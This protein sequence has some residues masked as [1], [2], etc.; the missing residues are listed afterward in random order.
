MPQVRSYNSHAAIAECPDDDDERYQCCCGIFHIV[1]GAKIVSVLLVVMAIAVVCFNHIIY[2]ESSSQ[3]NFSV[4]LYI[5]DVVILGYVGILSFGVFSRRRSLLLPFIVCQTITTA[6]FSLVLVSYAV[7]GSVTD[8]IRQQHN[9]ERLRAFYETQGWNP[10]DE[11]IQTIISCSILFVLLVICVCLVYTWTVF[12]FTYSYLKAREPCHHTCAIWAFCRKYT[13]WFPRLKSYLTLR[14]VAMLIIGR[15]LAGLI[16][17]VM[18]LAL[19]VMQLAL[20][21]TK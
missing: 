17:C 8:F 7:L 5:I 2:A 4:V 12:Y 21:A 9:N 3:T 1:T 13:S 19:E 11:K 6:I 15:L 14:D 10:N 18:Q 20:E 16:S